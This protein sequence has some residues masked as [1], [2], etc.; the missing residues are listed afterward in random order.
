MGSRGVVLIGLLV[1]GIMPG[2]AGAQSARPVPVLA[3]LFTSE[4]CNSCP[5]ADLLL[6]VLHNEQPFDG[7]YV[8]TLSEHVTYWD[9]QGW[10]D[11]FGAPQFTTRQQQYGRRFNTESIF[12]PQ[13]IVDG[14][15]EMVGSDKRAIAQALQD[16]GNTPKPELI[17]AARIADGAIEVT[18]SGAGL[19]AGKDG[20]LWFAVAEDRLVVDVKRGENAN[21]TLKHSGVVRVLRSVGNADR[22][23]TTSIKFEPAWKR[24]N[25]RIIAFVQSRKDRRVLSVGLTGLDPIKS[26]P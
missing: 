2:L 13:L 12:T 18:A 6:E 14:A 9:H 24:E 7:V 16:A 1:S 3:E 23:A 20:E 21:R 15:R 26:V 4:G 11:P 5:P 10:K 8:V 25:L 22:P 19:D 17:V